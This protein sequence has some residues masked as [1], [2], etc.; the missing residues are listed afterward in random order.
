MIIDALNEIAKDIIEKSEYTDNEVE[1]FRLYLNQTFGRL[2]D[3]Q[4]GNNSIQ[5]KENTKDDKC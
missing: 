3:C 1:Q 2:P 4:S 5:M